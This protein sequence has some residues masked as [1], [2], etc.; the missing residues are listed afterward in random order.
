MKHRLLIVD[1]DAVTSD[2]LRLIFEL[3]GYDVRACRAGDEGLEIATEWQPEILIAA[4]LLNGILGLEL[5]KR[6]VELYPKCH[7]I[8][9]ATV[10]NSF[11]VDGARA[12]GFDYYDKPVYPPVL[13]E[14]VRVVLSRQ[15]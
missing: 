15:G 11:L 10:A 5:G 12:L 13:I 6:V 1:Y 2:T 4:V 3:E 14:R 9:L 8:L 7:V